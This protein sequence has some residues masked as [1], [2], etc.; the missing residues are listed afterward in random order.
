MKT[1]HL[2]LLVLLGLPAASAFP[3]T[4]PDAPK[5]IPRFQ[6][7]FFE[8]EKFA[9]VKDSYS[10]TDRGRDAILSDIKNYIVQRAAVYVPDGQKLA[11]TITDIDLAGDFEPGAGPQWEDV[12]LV[13]E[14]YPPRINLTFKLTDANGNVLKT[15]TR[16]L[17]DLSFLMKLSVNN[18][19]PLR[20]EKNLLDDWFRSDFG[21]AH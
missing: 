13:K 10:G 6:V 14:I 5:P 11:V 12:R 7:S 18:G 3:P 1:P 9:D 8:P 15:G 19:D 21:R 17:Q 4:T 2:L 20:Y 16:R